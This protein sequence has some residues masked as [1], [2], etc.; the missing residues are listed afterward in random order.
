MK[1]AHVGLIADPSAPDST[2]AIA[3]CVVCHPDEV[4]A[5][6]NSLHTN[7]WGEIAAIE[8]RGGAG[9]TVRGT[10]LEPF[11]D[12][13]CATC[14]TTCGQ[15]HVSRPKSVGGGFP[16][17]ATQHNSHRFRAPDM[18]EQCTACHGSRIGTDF[19]GDLD[20]NTADVHYTKGIYC[21]DCHTKEEIH[22]DGL[23]DGEHYNHRY[24]VKSMPRCEDCHGVGKPEGWVNNGFHL[25]HVNDNEVGDHPN[26]QCQV[27]HSQP[28]KNCTNCHDLAPDG[29]VEKYTIN[30]SEVQFKIGRNTSPYRTEYDNVVVRHVPVDPGTY[31]DWGLVLTDYLESPTWKYASP[32][33]VV[34][35]T[36]QAASC[37]SCHDTID[38]PDNNQDGYFLRLSD[39]D[40]GGDPLPDRAA[41]LDVVI[42]DE[43]PPAK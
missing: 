1:E 24:E 41:N 19:K 6:A 14:H 15:C 43:F 20:G 39:L 5:T 4:A 22:G 29:L 32:H 12:A 31:D 2:G 34:R 9:C 11:F 26:L 3:A 23:S 35:N 8:S 10:D 38:D 7:L 16:L 28:Y 13:K 27:C 37:D 42:P 21:N 33:N 18:N 25:V 30:D 40:I 17:I 36:P